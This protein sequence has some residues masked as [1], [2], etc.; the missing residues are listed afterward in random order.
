[1]SETGGS[2]ESFSYALGKHSSEKKP[3]RATEE[4]ELPTAPMERTND[5][6]VIVEAMGRGTKS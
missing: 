3:E 2:S 4:V 5:K 6:D 1:M